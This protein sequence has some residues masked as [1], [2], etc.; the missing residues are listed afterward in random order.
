MSIG[1][2]FGGVPVNVTL[3]ATV[4]PALV[5]RFG[6]RAIVASAHSADAGNELHSHRNTTFRERESTEAITRPPDFGPNRLE[7]T[8]VRGEPRL[9]EH[10]LRRAQRLQRAEIVHEIPALIALDV[11]GERGHGSAI[12][13]RS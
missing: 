6:A 10:R 2:I 8:R 4:P 9:P 11:V 7:L 3:P 12:E 1:F 5:M 13:T